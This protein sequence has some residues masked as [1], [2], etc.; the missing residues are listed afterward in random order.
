MCGDATPVVSIRSPL[1]F[2]GASLLSALVFGVP[3]ASVMG[4][5][6]GGWTDGARDSEPSPRPCIV[7]APCVGEFG[8]KRS[9][10]QQP[11]DMVQCFGAN[12]KSSEWGKMCFLRL[13]LERP[14]AGL[15]AARQFT[16]VRGLDASRFG[17]PS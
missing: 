13:P 7:G 6:C 8:E 17:R 4:C 9:K 10:R 15:C 1:T 16:L 2:P 14:P 11:L 12:L 5:V 3:Q